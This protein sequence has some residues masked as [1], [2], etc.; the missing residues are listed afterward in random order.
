MK[1]NERS[2]QEQIAARSAEIGLISAAKVDEDELVIYGL[3][4]AR[5]HWC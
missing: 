5:T 2:T 1:Q 4:L 3:R